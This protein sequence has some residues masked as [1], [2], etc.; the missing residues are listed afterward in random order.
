MSDAVSQAGIEEQDKLKGIPNFRWVI[1]IML[2]LG[3][4]IQSADRVNLAVALPVISKNLGL[5]PTMM[6]IVISAFFWT[7]VAFN[8]PGGILVDKLKPRRTFTLIGA[9]WGITTM[10]TGLAIG[11]KTLMGSRIL[12]GAGEA[13]DFSAAARAVRDWFPTQERATATAIYSLG[14]DG[15]IIIGMPLAAWLLYTFGWRQVFYVFG[16]ISLLWT[17]AWWWLYD[18]PRK[19]K[20]LSKRE[21]DYIEQTG[22]IAVQPEASRLAT[23]FSTK[24]SWFSLFKHRQVWGITLGYFCYPFVYAFFY[25]WLPTYLVK[26]Q[27]FSIIKM[28]IY[29]ML[30]GIAALGGGLIGGYWSDAMVRRKRSLAVARKIP[31][32]IGMV[33]GAISIFAVGQAQHPL[34]AVVLLCLTA[35]IMRLAFGCILTTPNDIA[36]SAN[37]VGSITGIM[38]TAGMLG[39]GVISPI[40]TGII[41]T[42]TGSF[43]LAFLMMGLVALLGA[44][45][46]TFVTGPLR[47]IWREAEKH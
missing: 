11:F 22:A 31:I 32:S 38:V 39:G 4:T 37:Y 34:M 44:A 13:P 2:F 15:G 41:V 9:W 42:H 36:P 18:T 35:F 20:R 33:G 21:L 8:I 46:F 26:E 27:H 40:L 25:T 5:D 6:G 14:N 12:I 24:V 30:P 47:P 23:P 17:L 43:K 45:S 7:Y 28:G 19:H 16:A 10:M 1:A 29:G 3:I